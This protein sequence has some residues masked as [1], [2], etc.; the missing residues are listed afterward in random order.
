MTHASPERPTPQVLQE[1]YDAPHHG[2][3]EDVWDTLGRV[4]FVLVSLV[5]VLAVFFY[6]GWLFLA[7]NT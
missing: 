6:A 5:F 2:R 1:T 7:N 3:V 4:G